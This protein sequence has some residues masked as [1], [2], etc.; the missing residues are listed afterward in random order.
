[1]STG[2]SIYTRSWFALGSKTKNAGTYTV[3][4]TAR[5]FND[6]DSGTES[7]LTA[8][9]AAVPESL[10]PRGTDKSLLRI[11]HPTADS[12]AVSR[13]W[14][15][16]DMITGR[17]TVPYTYSLIFQGP[18]NN[19]FLS[20]PSHA[21]APNAMESYD[22]FCRRVNENPESPTV[23]A[24]EFDPQKDDYVVPRVMKQADW[25][26]KYRID[27][28]AFIKLFVSLM[29][30][31]CGRGTDKVSVV[32]PG[33]V[34][35]EEFLL[36]AMVC[37]P[38]FLRSKFGGSSDW[39]G[40]TDGQSAQSLTGIHLVCYHEETPSS[41]AKF[42]YFDLTGRVVRSENYREALPNER[43]FAQMLWNE[44]ENPVI[45][46]KFET[47]LYSEFADI[48]D[49]MKFGM[50][51]NCFWMQTNPLTESNALE[52]LKLITRSFKTL[53]SRY[54]FIDE[55]L[56][57]ALELLNG[58]IP[59]DLLENTD[60]VSTVIEMAKNGKTQAV[61]FTYDLYHTA[62]AGNHI[63]SA[64]SALEYFSTVLEKDYSNK[65]IAAIFQEAMPLQNE[66]IRKTAISTYRKYCL[67]LRKTAL[68][69]SIPDDRNAAFE[70]YKEAS[71][72]LKQYDIIDPKELNA[73]FFDL[74]TLLGGSKF[75]CKRLIPVSE[76]DMKS[77]GFIPDADYTVSAFEHFMEDDNKNDWM[78]LCELFYSFIHEEDYAALS[79]FLTELYA[80]PCWEYVFK[81]SPEI[82]DE[83]L[84]DRINADFQTSWKQF[85]SNRSDPFSE[86]ITWQALQNHGKNLQKMQ[87]SIEEIRS[88]FLSVIKLNYPQLDSL[89]RSFPDD[90][91]G[92][93]ML[94][95]LYKQE[96]ENI[97]RTLQMEQ[98]EF[99]R[100]QR[101]R[102]EREAYERE[103]RRWQQQQQQLQLQQQRQWDGA[104]SSSR[105]AEPIGFVL[106]IS[107]LLL[108]VVILVL[109]VCWGFMTGG[110]KGV[111]LSPIIR[112]TVIPCVFA[113]I[114]ILSSAA[115][116]I[117]AGGKK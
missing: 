56:N 98:E 2:H 26:S 111:K 61:N 113:G 66:N 77:L 7:K 50:A 14:F 108:D 19:A 112:N 64:A 37:L 23:P 114:V 32:L 17:G 5:I 59:A 95:F 80:K 92:R 31:I 25:Q 88:L 107:I 99:E 97:K 76:Y 104:M 35:G 84:R 86:E 24:T 62:I 102:L 49:Q 1:M 33:S 117:F 4:Q 70:S 53:Y 12:T 21:I 29:R 63:E 16:N 51:A 60:L 90:S 13:S 48:A 36:D 18:A 54:R 40:P 28:A 72:L 115:A 43:A 78:A 81:A 46:P 71:Q 10:A 106:K 101:A 3:E 85:V 105:A 22:S 103:Q 74:G 52:W 44:L 42:P 39:T 41:F 100:Q 55:N 47:W 83:I 79:R 65:R 94:A 67:H 38:M 93:K 69:S 91:A 96:V 8:F 15:V 57:K 110:F 73:E 11:S 75:P 58:N 89:Y 20:A 68:T 9:C 116:A 30:S 34:S 6:T 27:E 109:L 82:H 87:L 45:I